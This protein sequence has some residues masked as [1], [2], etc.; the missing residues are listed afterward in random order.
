MKDIRRRIAICDKIRRDIKAEKESCLWMDILYNLTIMKV[1]RQD[2]NAWS[3][4]RQVEQNEV[5]EGLERVL[6]AFLNDLM[7]NTNFIGEWVEIDYV[8]QILQDK[9]N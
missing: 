8:L 4:I 6:T 5:T 7:D 9:Q 1:P 3:K 2:T